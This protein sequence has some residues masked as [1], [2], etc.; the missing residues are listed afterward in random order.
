MAVVSDDH[1]DE[2]LNTESLGI[3]NSGDGSGGRRGPRLITEEEVM[4]DLRP[5]IFIIYGSD[6][7]SIMLGGGWWIC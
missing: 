2:S 1:G 7:S 4:M 5:G 6:Y 3:R